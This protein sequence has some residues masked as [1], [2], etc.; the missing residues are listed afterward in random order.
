[1]TYIRLP[2][3]ATRSDALDWCERHGYRPVFLEVGPDGSIR[4]LAVAE[5][6]TEEAP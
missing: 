3:M 5:R 4:G 1:V 6:D 2:M